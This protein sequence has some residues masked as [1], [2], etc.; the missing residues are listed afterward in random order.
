M[1][2]KEWRLNATTTRRTR[3]RRSLLRLVVV[4]VLQTS[5][6][7]QQQQRQ[8]QKQQ[9]QQQQQKQQQ[10]QQHY[11][12][13]CC[14]PPL[15]WF[16]ALSGRRHRRAYVLLWCLYVLWRRLELTQ[17]VRRQRGTPFFC[18][19][20]AQASPS[21]A[22]GATGTCT[23]RRPS[24]LCR[25]VRLQDRTATRRLWCFPGK[26]TASPRCF[27]PRVPTLARRRLPWR[28]TRMPSASRL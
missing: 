18:T 24:C 27:P 4:P 23:C 16:A 19:F 10:K 14:V 11:C 22:R 25:R 15:P 7:K 9:Q 3:R 17:V 13:C 8:K 20:S 5:T 1:M 12:Y 6:W 28:R 21:R 2:W 26:P